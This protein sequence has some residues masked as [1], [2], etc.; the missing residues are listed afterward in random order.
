MKRNTIFLVLLLSAV[1]S[2][3]VSGKAG[4]LDKYIQTALKQNPL[5]KSAK[6]KN[7]AD[8]EMWRGETTFRKN[9][10]LGIAYQNVPLQTWP[11]LDQTLMSG[12]VFS[13]TQEISMPWELTWRKRLAR[14]KEKISSVELELLKREIVFQVSSLFHK[15]N[16]LSYKTNIL[17]ESKKAFAEIVALARSLV[18]LN[19]MNSSQLL[20]LEADF[21]SIDNR[22]QLEE[23]DLIT[24]QKQMN[25]LLGGKNSNES[26]VDAAWM[27]TATEIPKRKFHLKDHPLYKLQKQ[28]SELARARLNLSR[29][30]LFP[31]VSLSVAYT[32]RQK[33][34]GQDGEDF[35]SFKASLPLPLFYPIKDRHSIKS[36]QHSF[37][38]AGEKQED[39]VNKMMKKWNSEKIQTRK[40]QHIFLNFHR[41]IVP[42][43]LA[44]YQSQLASLSSGTVQLIEVQDSY[45]KYLNAKMEE[46]IVFQRLQVSLARLNYL[47][48]SKVK[49]A[50][51]SK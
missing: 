10:V 14:K 35:I 29:A 36:A 6:F 45:R 12:V 17:K 32:A 41:K 4:G 9:P 34:S 8:E 31:S 3:A 51:K 38:E 20:K 49:P 42:N 39:I 26:F 47:Q 25:Y 33:V 1:L 2:L 5:L 48:P 24:A 37:R 21:Q 19:Q 28:K 13:M 22:I 30:R 7:Q 11:A 15:I 16:Y 23:S 46:A 44:A 27:K 40:L 43:Y 50:E 18:S